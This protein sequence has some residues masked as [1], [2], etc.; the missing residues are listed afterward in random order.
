MQRQCVTQCDVVWRCDAVCCNYCWKYFWT[1]LILSLSLSHLL[2]FNFLI[3][4]LMTCEFY[5]RPSKTEFPLKHISDL[6]LFYVNFR[7]TSTC[8]EN[9]FWTDLTMKKINSTSQFLTHLRP[10]YLNK[11]WNRRRSRKYKKARNRTCD[12]MGRMPRFCPCAEKLRCRYP[13]C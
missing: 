8:C 2:P 3:E 9:F 12:L 13:Q 4:L 1:S 6:Y 10:G 7:S 5:P 11:R